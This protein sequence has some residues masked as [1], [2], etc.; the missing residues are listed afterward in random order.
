MLLK[1]GVLRYMSEV[2][3]QILIFLTREMRRHWVLTIAEV[4]TPS[5]NP[6]P[7]LSDGDCVFVFRAGFS[8][9]TNGCGEG[10]DFTASISSIPNHDSDLYPMHL[11]CRQCAVQLCGVNSKRTRDSCPEGGV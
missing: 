8:N 7:C 3:A 1:V 6:K 4:L 2:E 10:Y 11:Q 9:E 5:V